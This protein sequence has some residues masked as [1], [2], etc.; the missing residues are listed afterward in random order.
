MAPK[1]RS[2]KRA[3]RA[4][5]RW[6]VERLLDTRVCDLDLRIEGTPLEARIAQLREELAARD[7]QLPVY[8]W[9]SDEWFTPARM[10]GTAIPFYLAHPRLIRLQ[11]SMGG[12]VEGAAHD[13]CMK[14]LRHEAGHVV[15]HAFR[16][17]LKRGKQQLFG[18]SSKNYPLSYRPNPYSKRHVQHLYYWYAQ[19]HPDEDF[20]ETFAVW[21]A[22]RSNWRQRYQGWPA[23]KKLEYVDAL[24]DE[25]AGRTPLVRS[26]ARYEPVESLELTLREYFEHQ[27]G[28]P[29]S[30]YPG[31]YDRDL[32]EV[33]TPQRGRDRERATVFVRRVR[34]EVI[35][36]LDRWL[37]EHRYQLEHVLQDVIVRC[38]ELGLYVKSSPRQARSDL[39]VMLTK[40]TM[41]SLYRQ[42]R[43]VQM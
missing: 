14:I 25:L 42:R 28:G 26:R 12:E 8:F 24:M 20:A 30:L 3:R 23:L 21:L 2:S 40:H 5:I 19:A 31:L 34:G 9:L 41:T 27:R 6:P 11:R 16:L 18:L 7:L 33:F 36:E 38:R 22:P 35:Q 43:W 37:G 13:W 39:V 4:W 10:I 17:H 32:Y 29:T 1:T 15:D